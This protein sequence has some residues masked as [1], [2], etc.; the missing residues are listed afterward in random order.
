[1]NTTRRL[2]PECLAGVRFSEEK[3]P[4]ENGRAGEIRTHDLLH[5]MQARYQA[6]LQPEQMKGQKA[7]CPEP[8][9]VLFPLLGASVTQGKAELTG[10][11]QPWASALSN[12]PH[13]E[14]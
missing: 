13:H 14:L 12:K 1:V 4:L 6:T 5:P 11:S 3:G 8:R 7:G 10:L 9:Q 2:G